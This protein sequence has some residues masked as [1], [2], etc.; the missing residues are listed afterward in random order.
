M[1]K[2]LRGKL[3]KFEED[4][5]AEL[6]SQ[7]EAEL[8][9]EMAKE[10]GGEAADEPKATPV[11]VEPAPAVEP[12]RPVEPEPTPEP[13]PQATPER[14]LA[15]EPDA[16]PEPAPAPTPEPEVAAAPEP[17]PE[18]GAPP[19]PPTFTEAH[20]VAEPKRIRKPGGPVKK[21]DREL[22]DEIAA[23]LE[24]EMGRAV[25]S[26][27]TIERSVHET[28]AG[29]TKVQI[30]PERLEDLLWELELALLESDVA[31]PVV[32]AI[33]NNVAEQLRE[34]RVS[35]KGAAELVQRVLKAAVRDV[36]NETFD[37][38]AYVA[39]AEKPAVIMF[40]GVNGTGKTTCIAKIAHRLKKSGYSS[41]MAAGDTFRA[42]AVAQLG[43]HADR[44]GV[45]LIKHEGKN[46]DPAAVG[47]DAIEHAQSRHKDVVLLDT[48]GRMGTNVNLMDEMEKIKRVCKPDLIFFVGDSLAGND[49]VDQAAKFNEIVG[50]DGVILTKVDADAKGGAAL[51]VAYAIGK[52]LVFIGLGQEY[53]DL[54]PFD[55]DW[56]VERLFSEEEEAV[57]AA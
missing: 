57:A 16:T 50:L 31:L 27:K 36:L 6:E 19:A 33:K 38:D 47:F 43:Q 49:A 35:R 42:G 26:Q 53:E 4:L 5:E 2:K 48:A 51:S 25:A 15:P 44:L 3:A 9:A 32:E 52:P 14:V 22:E 7:L 37:F 40:V 11:P 34:A 56:M 24:A 45:K 41:V 8:E 21:T 10:L 54:V 23:S 13:A 17:E 12:A 30:S 1:F 20:P 29:G 55:R 46:A 18:P 28:D 39:A